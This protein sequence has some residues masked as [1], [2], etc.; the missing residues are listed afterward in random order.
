M[1]F[2]PN[3]CEIDEDSLAV[4]VTWSATIEIEGTGEKSAAEGEIEVDFDI[5]NANCKPNF[6]LESDPKLHE[7]LVQS[8]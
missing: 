4:G 2:H 3:F 7:R 6:I 1:L 8:C 5:L